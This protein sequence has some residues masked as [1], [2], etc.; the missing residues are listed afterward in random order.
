MSSSTPFGRGANIVCACVFATMLAGCAVVTVA[1]TV[2]GVAVTGA[3][4]AVDAA[5][6]AARITGKAVGAAAD[7]VLPGEPE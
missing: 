4:L 1:G 3:G 5:V 2:A 7:M 6:G